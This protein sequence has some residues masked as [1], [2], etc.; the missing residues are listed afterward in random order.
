V[1]SKPGEI[2]REEE[3]VRKHTTPAYRAP[4]LWDL[5]AREPL[6]RA[7]DMWSLGCLLYLLAYGKYPFDPDA[8]LQILNG[9]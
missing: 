5:Y 7:V 8:K 2:A 6:G 9:R 1:I 3:W 4:E